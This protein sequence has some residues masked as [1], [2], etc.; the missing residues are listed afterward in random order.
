MGNLFHQDEIN[1]DV[2]KYLLQQFYATICVTKD[3]RLRVVPRHN[4]DHQGPSYQ[5]LLCRTAVV[6]T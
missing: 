2:L 5:I 1:D 6:D 3:L 4:L